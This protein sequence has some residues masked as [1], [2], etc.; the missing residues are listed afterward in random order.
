MIVLSQ[1]IYT[2]ARAR[3]CVQASSSDI[4]KI[5][6]TNILGEYNIKHDNIE[7][8]TELEIFSKIVFCCI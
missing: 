3:V 8:E 1:Y 2:C 4:L 6:L 7:S 5:E